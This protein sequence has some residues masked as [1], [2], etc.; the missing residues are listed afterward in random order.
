[1]IVFSASYSTCGYW[2]IIVICFNL[3]YFHVFLPVFCVGIGL[4]AIKCDAFL[5]SLNFLPSKTTSSS[6]CWTLLFVSW[7]YVGLAWSRFLIVLPILRRVFTLIILFNRR[8]SAVCKYNFPSCRL[9][10]L[11]FNLCTN[12]AAT[13]RCYCK[14]AMIYWN[15]LVTNARLLIAVVAGDVLT[16]VL[17]LVG[18]FDCIPLCTLK[19]ST[20]DSE[21]RCL[22]P[23]RFWIPE[24]SNRQPARIKAHHNTLSSSSRRSSQHRSLRSLRAHLHVYLQ[25]ILQGLES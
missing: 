17:V 20:H 16:G 11:S 3:Q 15:L 14:S 8:F 6:H 19:G 4:I 21:R 24:L 12:K 25:N 22:C 13:V 9:S 5:C 1:M 18:S 2:L 10:R 7:L 23:C